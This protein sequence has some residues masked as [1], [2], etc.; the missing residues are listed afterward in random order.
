VFL[1]SAVAA[2]L[3]GL[4]FGLL[5]ALRTA[6]TA[7]L[8]HARAA[9]AARGWL[10]GTLVTAQIAVSLVLLNS[11]GLLLRS[12]D[13]LQH[14]TMGFES[15]HALTVNFVLGRQRYSRDIDQL[16]LFR[17]LEERL[18]ALPG[19][20]AAAI[21]DSVPPTGG[22]RGRPLSTI[23][24]EGRPSRAEGS[25][26]MVAWRYV[27]PG[28]FAALSIP[29][30]RG[31]GFTEADRAPQAYCVVLND[32]LAKL[33]FGGEDPLGRR[34][35]RG[36]KGE[37]FTVI[38]VTADVRNAGLEKKMAPEYYFVRKS[39][40]DL[41]WAN[42]EPPLGW[43]GAVAVVR[44]ER[45]PKQAAA[46]VRSVFAG[47]D[48]TLPV[49]INTLQERVASGRGRPRFQAMLL[50]SFAAIGLL[51][52]AIGLSGVMAFL[53]EQRRQEIGV[54]MALGATPMGMVRLTVSFA[55]RWTFAGILI[56]GAGALTA[57]RWLR[58]QLFHVDSA[59]P[60]LFLAAIAL[61]ILVAL[62]ASAGPA[63]RAAAIDPMAA[64]RAE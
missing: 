27:S 32:T 11:A 21:S 43:R 18:A 45:E 55:A 52:A 9:G 3:C 59:N 56:G 63:R 22:T 34:I 64:L 17:A 48:P 24:V 46:A 47:L 62:A 41:T 10:R 37:W 12:L 30:R 19:V 38:G 23:E 25:G 20:T 14:V 58:S 40:P 13:N 51:L 26:G 16:A 15:E 35:Q 42:Q 61:L 50:G 5:P 39:V 60:S 1:F 4:L 28:Y 53:V 8:G 44:T 29:L 7:T 57:G 49:E 36:P 6:R 54:R 33:L 31:R 2:G